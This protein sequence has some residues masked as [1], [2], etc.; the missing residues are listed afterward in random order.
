MALHQLEMTSND[1]FTSLPL[2]LVSRATTLSPPL[3]L[4][5]LDDDLEVMEAS[6]KNLGSEVKVA[7]EVLVT[8]A[9]NRFPLKISINFVKAEEG[10]LFLRKHIFL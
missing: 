7:C 8:G 5:P 2:T 9:P 10:V 1:N 4:F 6:L 3:D